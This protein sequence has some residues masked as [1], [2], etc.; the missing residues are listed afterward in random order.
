MRI[1]YWLA[2]A[3]LL[4]VLW[5]LFV[6]QLAPHDLLVGIAAAALGASATEAVGGCEHP[7]FLPHVEWLIRSW[8]LPFEILRDCGLLIRNLFDGRPG[9]SETPRFEAGGDD[10]RSVARRALATFYTTLPPNTVVIGID[11]PRHTMLL[12]RLEGTSS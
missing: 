6:A 8:R 12:H 4:Y 1:V 11:R 7:R 10:A 9:H 2:E 3:A 5:L